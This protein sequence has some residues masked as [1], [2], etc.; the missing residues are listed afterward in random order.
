M[1]Q[2]YHEHRIFVILMGLAAICLILILFLLFR[3][4]YFGSSRNAPRR[5][6]ENINEAVKVEKVSGLKEDKVIND[7]DIRVNDRSNIIFV[8]INFNYEATLE[9]AKGKA[10]TAYEKF[11]EEAKECYDFQFMLVQP[12]TEGTE[13]FRIMGARNLTG[14]N[15]VWNN[16][17]AVDNKED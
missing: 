11:D 3:Y 5:T 12:A 2:F 10:I 6:C 8:T 14:T 16:N 7:A 9:V 17:T 15:F 4:F 1:K 13:G